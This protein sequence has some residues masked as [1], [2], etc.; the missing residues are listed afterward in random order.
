[1]QI[2]QWAR[3]NGCP[4]TERTCTAA[5]DQ[6]RLAV[7]QWARANGCPWDEEVCKAAAAA[8]H[9]EVLQWARAMIRY[10][11]KRQRWPYSGSEQTH[12]EALVLLTSCALLKTAYFRSAPEV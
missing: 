11:P 5:A 12:A 9:P 8:G 6:G 3:A 2:L 1:M 10:R 7:L 4:W